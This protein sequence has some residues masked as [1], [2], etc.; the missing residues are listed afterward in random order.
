MIR[1]LKHDAT[2]GNGRWSR[3]RSAF[4]DY[5]TRL[6][7]AANYGGDGTTHVAYQILCN[8][9]SQDLLYSLLDFLWTL[10]CFYCYPSFVISLTCN[11]QPLQTWST[12]LPLSRKSAM[13][14]VVW[15]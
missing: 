15:M 1:V 2:D 12:P 10:D 11:I 4:T 9:F 5:D 14:I 3:V 13:Q 7:F 8:F 6:S